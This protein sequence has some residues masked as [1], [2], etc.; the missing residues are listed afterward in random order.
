MDDLTLLIRRARDGDAQAREAV[1]RITYHDL[2][3]LARAQLAR[4]SRD[5]SLDTVAVV[6]EAYLRLASARGLRAEDR[7]QYF[8]YA[9]RVMRSVIIDFVR[10]R[11]A[12]RRGGRVQ[13]VRLTTQMADNVGNDD[14]QLLRVHEALEE[15]ASIDAR[16][17]QVVEMK[18][19]AGLGFREIA[20]ALGVAERTVRRDW[21]KARLL[22]SAAL[23]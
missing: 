1:F 5:G 4:G 11:A 23:K 6:N 21:E 2:K 12:E 14:E 19:F 18:Y 7:G 9:G 16:M 22:L 15:L 3:Q 20:L 13:H 10:A 8:A 17:V